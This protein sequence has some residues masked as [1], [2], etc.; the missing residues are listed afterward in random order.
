MD[1]IRNN[2]LLHT[3]MDIDAEGGI[4]N[5]PGK[6][7]Q[8]IRLDGRSQY[9]DIGQH[10]SNCFGD[11]S[12]CRHGITGSMW[13]NFRKFGN[14]MFYFSNG[15]GVK[16][17]HKNGR[18]Y[19]V[20]QS[21]GKEWEIA[22]PDLALNQWYFLEYSWHPERGL[23]VF[24]NNKLMGYQSNPRIIPAQ[25][26]NSDA[27]VYIGRANNG[28]TS[29]GSF[30]FANALIDEA[31]TWFRDR[32]TLLAFGYILRGISHRRKEIPKSNGQYFLLLL[33]RYHSSF[34]TIYLTLLACAVLFY[35]ILFLPTVVTLFSSKSFLSF[36]CTVIPLWH[37]SPCSSYC[38]K[39]A[40]MVTSVSPSTLHHV[41][42]RNKL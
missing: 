25:D 41:R 4:V 6:L 39:H 42:N 23:Q 34:T 15:N 1:A 28:D 36:W 7:Q 9:L 32:D 22:V 16:L 27:H 40:T 2:K 24:I 38:L 12:K 17:Y 29:T 11:L 3:S 31:E 14:N 10:L 20:L 5:I 19:F 13:A 18:L 26:L 30:N 37:H 33:L 21:G 8:G 35:Y